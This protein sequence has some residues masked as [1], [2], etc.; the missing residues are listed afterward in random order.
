MDYTTDYDLFADL[1][2]QQ[3]AHYRD[4]L[5][6]YRRLAEDYGGPVLELGAGGARVS[7]ALA[8]VGVEVDAIEIAAKMIEKGKDALEEDGLGA[9]VRYHQADMRAV[10]LEPSHH[11][12]LVIA[13][14]NALMHAYTLR[15]QNATL[16]TVTHHLKKGGRFAC[17][18]Y[19]PDFGPMGVLRHVTEWDGIGGDHSTLF[20]LQHHDRAAQLVET[21]YYLDTVGEN[22]ALTRQTATLTQRYYTRFE[23]ERLLYQ[24][25][26]AQVQLYG[27]FGRERYH[28][29]APHMVFIASR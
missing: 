8:K 12:P 17:D 21:R 6:F 1:Y 3:Y 9:K 23:F 29:D 13:P 11:H 25:G 14:F 4:D 22:G 26:F 15:D 20:L 2:E 10:R 27:D 5:D 19:T 18:L 24:A 7:R 16:A 28:A